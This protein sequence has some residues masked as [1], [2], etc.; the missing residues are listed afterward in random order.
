MVGRPARGQ[1]TSAAQRH[2]WFRLPR[3]N[4]RIPLAMTVKFRGGPE[5]WVE[6]HC[7][8]GVHRFPGYTDI[9]SIVL[10]ANGALGPDTEKKG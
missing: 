3:R 4:P 5:A 6:I 8:G 9:A 2:L 10:L 1:K 7:R